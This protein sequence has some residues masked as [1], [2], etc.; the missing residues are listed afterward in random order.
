MA[1]L[2]TKVLIEAVRRDGFIR[3]AAALLLP[4]G[5]VVAGTLPQVPRVGDSYQITLVKDSV[6]KGS[7]G[8]SGTTH[9]KDTIIERVTG[10]RADGA[11]LQYDLANTATAEERTREWQ[12]PAEVFKPFAGPAQLLNGSEMET[13]IEIWLKAASL[14][15][16]ACGHWVFTWNAFR[17]ECDP[18]SVLKTLQMY[19]LRSVDLR[20]GAAYQD[21][22]ASSTGKLVRKAGG[23][24]GE[25][26]AA[27]MPID[28]DKVRHARA[29]SDAVV[30]E[31][32]K[33]PVSLE[34]ALH[35]HEADIVSG[36]ISVVFD[37]DP[38]GNVRRRT[39]ITK[40][41]IKRPD[42]TTETQSVTETLER[43][44]ISRRD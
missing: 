19:D 1:G 39:R 25:S 21:S 5:A 11:E 35:E 31:I 23:I 32:L 12:F 33:K 36:T 9:D 20:E 6:R 15:R 13:R 7:N 27:E 14:S 34:K 42:G 4:A 18:H 17:I 26:F 44:L 24:D 2:L 30:G 8:S 28:S 10:L 41:D 22:E 40:L 38:D 16:A 43:R 37:T 29:E 3:M